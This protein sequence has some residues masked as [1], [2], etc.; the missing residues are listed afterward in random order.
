[1][2]KRGRPAKAEKDKLKKIDTNLS[3]GEIARAD[4]WAKKLN[5]GSRSQFIR[6]SVVKRMRTLEK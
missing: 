3:P 1:M 2:R 5:K 6:E 4:K